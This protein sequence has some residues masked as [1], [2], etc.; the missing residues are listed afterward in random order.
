MRTPGLLIA[1]AGSWCFVFSL[2]QFSKSDSPF[3]FPVFSSRSLLSPTF[4]LL[5]G[6]RTGN[7]LDVVR[8]SSEQ[9]FIAAFCSAAAVSIVTFLN[10]ASRRPETLFPGPGFP[11]GGRRPIDAVISVAKANGKSC[12]VENADAAW[13]GGES[14]ACAWDFGRCALWLAHEAAWKL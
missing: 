6:W 10:G 13:D 14:S 8:H 1:G 9:H 7:A 12:G 5:P 3:T 2:R 11:Q 4:S